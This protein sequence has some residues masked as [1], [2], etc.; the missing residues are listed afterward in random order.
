MRVA[1]PQAQRLDEG[2]AAFRRRRL[3]GATEVHAGGGP[4]RFAFADASQPALLVVCEPGLGPG[5]EA[6]LRETARVLRDN[7]RFALRL[8]QRPARWSLPQRLAACVPGRDGRDGPLTWRATCELSSWQG[9]WVDAHLL[10]GVLPAPRRR[11]RRLPAWL[12]PLAAEVVL[13]G[14]RIPREVHDAH[15]AVRR[16]IAET[17]RTESVCCGSSMSPT[18]DIGDHLTFVPCAHPR[19]GD[20][21]LLLCGGGLVTHRV[22][23]T[24]T[25]GDQ[26]WIGHRGDRPGA[27]SAIAARWR[28]VGRLESVKRLE[29]SRAGGD[30]RRKMATSAGAAPAA[31]DRR[32]AHAP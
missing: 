28:V 12:L 2:F 17:G 25:H 20:V 3:L 14:H 23:W 16:S 31:G 18:F 1:S 21:V 13:S 6:V 5:L 30:R 9:L 4:V 15:S 24:L 27:R 8:P 29:R 26:G 19:R 22:T 32:R 10:Q 11:P 7:G